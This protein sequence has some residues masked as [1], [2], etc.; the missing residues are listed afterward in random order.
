MVGC[1]LQSFEEPHSSKRRATIGIV[2]WDK[3]RDIHQAPLWTFSFSSIFAYLRLI[4][5][6]V[7]SFINGHLGVEV[8]SFHLYSF[9]PPFD[10]SAFL[11]RAEV[12]FSFSFLCS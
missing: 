8:F 12:Q 10:T 6:S 4:V 11:F 5:A 7:F 9:A 2:C 1:R 3:S